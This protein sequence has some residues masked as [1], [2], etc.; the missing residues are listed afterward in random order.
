MNTL[1]PLRIWCIDW[2]DHNKS[3][4]SIS[5]VFFSVN[6]HQTW[7]RGFPFWWRSGGHSHPT[8][9]PLLHPEARGHRE[10]HVHVAFDPWPQ[11]QGVGLGGGGGVWDICELKQK[12][13]QNV[14]CMFRLS[15]QKNMDFQKLKV[16]PHTKNVVATKFLL[17]LRW[18]D[19][20]IDRVEE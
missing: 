12:Y 19:G 5:R 13:I 6:S 10:L 4:N 14:M 7:S 18:M 9:R 15:V 17:L 2:F 1:F 3:R 8:E 16:L 11:V 20:F